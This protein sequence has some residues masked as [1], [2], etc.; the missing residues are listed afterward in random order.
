MPVYWTDPPVAQFRMPSPAESCAFCG[1][2]HVP[3][4]PCDPRK[5]SGL[6]R[7]ILRDLPDDWPW[8]LTNYDLAFLYNLKISR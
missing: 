2:L 3:E 5:L 1:D 6:L 4:S 8:P 7:F